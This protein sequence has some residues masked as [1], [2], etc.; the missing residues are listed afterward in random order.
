MRNMKLYFEFLS[1]RVIAGSGE[2][3]IAT[4]VGKGI[5]KAGEPV[6]L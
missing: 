1:S 2:K 3:R 4:E 5:D 6:F